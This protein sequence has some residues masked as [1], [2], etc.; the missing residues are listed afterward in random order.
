M[1]QINQRKKREFQSFTTI[2]DVI[3]ILRSQ[4]STRKL[5]IKY[6]VPKMEATI[7]EF[8]PDG[9]MMVVTDP[10]YEHADKEII[11]YGLS[12]KYLEIDLEVVEN[13]GPGYF[14]CKIKSARRAT[15]GRRD[16]R[17]KVAPDEVVATNFKVSRHMIGIT[18]YNIPTSIKVVLD[19]FQNKN[20]KISDIFKV[21]IFST[22][23]K[24]P[25]MS[26]MRKSGKVLYVA[27][28]ADPASYK[29][30]NDDFIDPEDLFGKNLQ[31]YLLKNVEKGY[32]SILVV[33]IIYIADNDSSV[34]FAYIQLISK[35]KQFSLDDV[36]EIKDHAF[37][38]VDRIRD[39]NTL[40]LQV[41]Q[42]VVDISRGGAKL[43]ID[44]AQLRQYIAKSRGF[45]FDLVFKLQAPITIYGE[46]R[47]TYTDEDGNLFVGVD[48][49]GNSSRKDE[50]KRYYSIIKPMEAEYKSRLIRTMKAK[51]ATSPE[52]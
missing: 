37:K 3:N 40:L 8:M 33:P 51:K 10:N 14:M 34:P 43:K 49:E 20:S 11:L 30:M 39:A 5:Y 24:D 19:Q 45:I 4:F 22:D 32:K 27:D 23:D 13:R 18:S 41:H 47:V 48:F 44:D 35:S 38:L 50:M 12:D 21:D 28:A 9:T 31:S 36:L 26:D 52:T 42:T 29:P 2:N 6:A 17:F 46:I 1:Q 7:N 16:L 15:R 25:V